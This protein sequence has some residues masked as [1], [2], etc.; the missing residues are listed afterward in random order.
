MTPAARRSTARRY[1]AR[2]RHEARQLHDAGWKSWSIHKLLVK[3]MGADAPS[4]ST[5]L[6]WVDDERYERHKQSAR[7]RSDRSQA[8]GGAFR[9][10]GRSAAYRA[11]FSRRA[12]AAGL[13][14]SAVVKASGVVLDR[15][16]SLDEVDRALEDGAA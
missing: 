14:R 8:A 9:L 2:L 13:T 6:Y 5:L 12:F 4:Y 10:R 16:L 3:R 1:P 7:A 15:P 11:E